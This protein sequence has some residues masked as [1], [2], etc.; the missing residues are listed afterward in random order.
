MTASTASAD[1]AEDLG[2]SEPD[3][4]IAENYNSNRQK[5][6]SVDQQTAKNIRLLERS[7][8]DDRKFNGSELIEMLETEYLND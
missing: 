2:H 7:L 1:F 3:N 6:T 4:Q 8:S 5:S